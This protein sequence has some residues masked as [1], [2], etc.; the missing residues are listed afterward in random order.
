MHYIYILYE[1]IQFAIAIQI[2]V[3]GC[4]SSLVIDSDLVIFWKAQ[5]HHILPDESLSQELNWAQSD[6]LK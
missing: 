1:F 5:T 4:D 6:H 3:M 2:I